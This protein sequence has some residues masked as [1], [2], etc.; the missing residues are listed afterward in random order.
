[1]TDACNARHHL[2]GPEVSIPKVVNSLQVCA[3]WLWCTL[4]PNCVA[5]QSDEEEDEVEDGLACLESLGKLKQTLHCLPTGKFDDKLKDVSP[6][7]K[8]QL[9]FALQCLGWIS[10]PWTKMVCTKPPVAMFETNWRGLS[11]TSATD[12]AISSII[13]RET[14]ATGGVRA[15][16]SGSTAGDSW[17]RWSSAFAI[18]ICSWMQ[19]KEASLSKFSNGDSL[20]YFRKAFDDHLPKIW[21]LQRSTPSFTRCCA[22]EDLAEWPENLKA[23]L[24]ALRSIPLKHAMVSNVFDHPTLLDFPPAEVGRIHCATFPCILLAISTWSSKAWNGH[25]DFGVV[26]QEQQCERIVPKARW[27][28]FEFGNF[29]SAFLTSWS[30]TTW[31]T[32]A[33]LAS[34]SLRSHHDATNVARPGEA[35]PVLCTDW[36]R[37]KAANND[38]SKAWAWWPGP[39]LRSQLLLACLYAKCKQADQ[40]PPRS[41]WSRLATSR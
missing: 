32:L 30:K 36:S 16:G 40:T 5:H 1:M 20:M 18:L 12:G 10:S 2:G 6:R 24:S 29:Q 27:S 35:G 23:P 17:I 37:G 31:L 38:R 14:C 9:H 28:V 22:P 26:S 15:A 39:K 8:C 21:T 34:I 41:M 33:C 25:T 11:W 19:F 3:L 7:P 13:S 4:C